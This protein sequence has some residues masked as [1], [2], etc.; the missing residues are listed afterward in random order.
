MRSKKSSD[1]NRDR[2]AKSVFNANRPESQ[3]HHT[4]LNKHPAVTLSGIK[5]RPDEVAALIGVSTKTLAN[6]RYRGVGPQ[7]IKLGG[8]RGSKA[9]VRY[10]QD[11]VQLWLQESTM[12]S[13]A[14]LEAD[15][16]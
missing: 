15:D 14:S 5:L 13:A 7:F 9:A 1:V 16:E 6:W 2:N 3:T 10:D 4:T 11:A 12:L 8:I